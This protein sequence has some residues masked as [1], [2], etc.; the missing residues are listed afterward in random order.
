[1]DL[2]LKPKN[3]FEKTAGAVDLPED[4]NAWPKEILDELYKQVPYISDFQPNVEMSKVDPEMA[5]GL[6]HIEVM[7]HTS[8]NP[9]QPESMISTNVRT[10]RIPVIIKDGALSPFDIFIDDTNRTLPLTEARLRQALFRPQ[11]F[12]SVG[13]GPGDVSTVSQLYPPLRQSHGFGGGAMQMAK[14]GSALESWLIDE[15][16][17]QDGG[18]RR[19]K[20]KVASATPMFRKTG[21]M[22]STISPTINQDDMQVFCT[23]LEDENTRLYL[24]KNA[25]ATKE[26]VGKILQ[27]EPLS[28]EKLASFAE[29]HLRPNV[30]QVS[31][32]ETG[33]L[34]K[35]AN[36]AFWEPKFERI[37]R[38]QLVSQFGEKVALAVDTAGS[39]TMGETGTAEEATKAPLQPVIESGLY[40]VYDLEGK[41]IVGS[42]L[43]NLYDADG[44][45]VPLSLF[46]NGSQSTVQ[47][48]I[49]GNRMDGTVALSASKP[50]GTGVFF[51]LTGE[52]GPEGTVPFTIHNSASMPGE[53]GVIHAET[54]E[55]TPIDLSIQE[56]AVPTAT[57]EGRLLIPSSWS[58]T[59]LEGA[60]EVSL[61][62]GPESPEVA[63][64]KAAALHVSS[65]D[66]E[67]FTFWGEPVEKLA[68]DERAQVDVDQALFLLT[69]LGVDQRHSVQKLAA[70]S[71]GLQPETLFVHRDLKP[72]NLLRE[73][74]VKMAQV[75]HADR[76]PLKRYLLKEAASIPDPAAV[77]VVLSLGF[78]NEENLM[79]FV[80]Y[81]PVIDD[82]QKKMCELLL[83]C[84]LG[85][86]EIP[87][88]ALERAIR[89]TE[90]VVEGLKVIAFQGR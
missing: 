10:L 8:A 32:V 85:I 30:I 47:A 33:Y 23:A 35:K 66:G 69:A 28:A 75:R 83:G 31:K 59:S 70:A 89:S 60:A 20:E 64:E 78:I 73:E 72:A 61:A 50:F 44:E 4:P 11:I 54:M 55:G 90:E 51:T 24:R 6:G 80:S 34:V 16:E 13:E 5:Y 43:T 49:F 77:D 87:E 21:S 48:E 52:R 76:I 63:P 18:F 58:W 2:F 39:V 41:K 40:E 84:R 62:G 68:S 67:A 36:S 56:I 9:E 14:I 15:L 45:R 29:S 82:A 65:S 38:G 88:G 25:A 26:A 46:S 42:V 86:S 79:T 7:N 3:D 57:P 17:K 19:P 27:S 12:D 37:H 22:L 1:M 74:V 81:L 53:P 71:S